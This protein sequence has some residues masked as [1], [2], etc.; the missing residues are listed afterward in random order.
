MP[1]LMKA[2]HERTESPVLNLWGFFGGK[3]ICYM[4]S[5]SGGK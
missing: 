3:K 4:R 1:N 5:D 2:S